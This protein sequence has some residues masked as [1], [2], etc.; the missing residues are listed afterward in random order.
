MELYPISHAN[1]SNGF[2]DATRSGSGTTAQSSDSQKDQ[3]GS[4]DRVTISQEGKEKS[5]DFGSPLVSEKSSTEPGTE[6][7]NQQELKQIQ[8]LKRRDA[9]VRTHEQ[10]HLSAAGRY[11]TSG[12]S[13]TYQ[14]GPDGGSYAIG[15]EV[16]IDTSKESTPEATITK[17][18][19][20]KR[21]ALAPADPSGADKRIAANANSVEVQARQELLQNEQEVLLQGESTTSSPSKNHIATSNNDPKMTASTQGSLKTKLAVYA[22][23]A[24]Y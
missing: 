6:N 22:N 12:A 11:A 10:T 20:I 3:S 13:F 17:M 21:A 9:E 15:G 19:T 14:K 4:E 5:S 24:A 2:I 8:Q 16:N 7:L 1:I 23:M 18:Q